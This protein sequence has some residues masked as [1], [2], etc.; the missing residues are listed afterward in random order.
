MRVLIVVHGFPPL[1][2]GGSEIHAYDHALALRQRFGDEVLVLTREQDAGRPEYGVR[3]EDRDGLRIAWVNNTFRSVSSFEATY[4]NP[5]IGAIAEGI[6]DDFRPDVA[7]VHHLTCLS[8]TIVS[9]LAERRVPI[10]VTLHDYWLICHR[11]QLLD[12]GY[13][14]CDR[15]EDGGCT[16]CLGAAA[17]AGRVGFTGASAVRAAERYLP[18]ARHM[19]RLGERVLLATLPAAAGSDEQRKRLDHM[20]AICTQVTEFLAPSRCLRD[21][22][23]RF[24]IDV[25][26]IVE[27]P[28][29]V[30]A[31]P[32]MLGRRTPSTRL[33]LGFV[34]SLMISKAPH[35]LLEAA[36]M[37]PQDAVSVELYG[38]HVP[39]HGDDS[40][41]GL[42]EPFLNAPNVHLHGPVPRAQIP[43]TF[44]SIDVL[45]VTS[46]WPE[47]SPFVIHEAFLAGVPVVASRIGGIP[48]LIEDGRNGLLFRPGD[49]A[50]LAAT[51]RR[52]LDD[53]A[54]LP[55]LRSAQTPVRTLDDEVA[56]MRQ[57]YERYLADARRLADDPASM[58]DKPVRLAAVVLNFRTPDD[59]WLAVKSLIASDRPVDHL[60]VVD[61]DELQDGSIAGL[62]EVRGVEYLATGR[63]LGFSGGMN[64]GI[65]R[66]LEAGADR[67]VL[68]NSDV[69]VPP[70][71]LGRLERALRESSTAGIVAPLLRSRSWPDRIASQGIDYTR[72]TGRMRHRA[73]GALAPVDRRN[74]AAQGET[75]AA[76]GTKVD[77]VSGCVMLVERRVFDSVGLFDEAYFYGFEDLDLCLRASQAGFSSLVVPSAAAYHE[78]GRS[79]GA[80]SPRRLYFAARNHLRMAHSAA[81]GEGGWRSLMR[82]PIIVML[83][84]AHA[85]RAQGGS[86]ISRI[87]AVLRGTRDYMIGRFGSGEGD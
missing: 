53:S 51:L 78:S 74:E 5:T 28:Y 66:A 26:R 14:V 19:R 69:Y 37:L 65:R 82:A 54:L 36:A 16:S 61:N 49:A 85:V 77:A 12:T 64:A 75:A 23:I 62:Q 27:S 76:R 2:Q 56:W 9:S 46:I 45:A 73:A 68:V 80:G 25:D 57:R 63:N 40:Y 24:G 39:Y 4:R 30:D 32:F 41:K 86:P 42:L 38:A 29:G 44:A 47:N 31:G 3:W 34:G 6:V 8:T 33:R 10:V 18:A 67:V 15:P 72:S 1:A 58:P 17:G 7:H 22:F 59:T 81:A 20:R 71:C 43:A 55:R 87:A 21:R 60:I 11:G 48:E 35:L 79:I 70:D 52:C 83:N 84:L 50:D 13:T